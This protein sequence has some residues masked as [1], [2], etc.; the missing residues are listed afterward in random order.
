M[1]GDG[2]TFGSKGNRDGTATFVDGPQG[3]E[4]EIAD[5]VVDGVTLELLDSLESMGMVADENVG[6]GLYQLVGFMALARNGLKGVFTA[7]MKR[8]D[9]D[10]G[11]VRSSQ[12]EDTL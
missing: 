9:D 8:N 1:G 12:A 10:C 4:D 6:T 5:T 2:C 3:I 11:G 7:P